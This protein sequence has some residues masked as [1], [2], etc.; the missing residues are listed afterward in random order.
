MI[1]RD[2]SKAVDKILHKGIEWKI[3]NLNLPPKFGH[4][5]SSFLDYRNSRIELNN[6]LGES[7][8]FVNG[9]FQGYIP[10]PTLFLC[11]TSGIP[12]SGPRAVDIMFVDDITQIMIYQH[13]S[14][15]R[16]VRKPVREIDRVNRYEYCTSG[17]SE[18]I[19]K[20]VNSFRYQISSQR[21]SNSR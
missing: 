21:G 10:S 12:P 14:K 2:S 16:L 20:N 11:Y 5:L 15:E 3:L 17:K 13:T 18:Q 8:P 1:W 19:K 9:V 6:Q 4:I 7:F